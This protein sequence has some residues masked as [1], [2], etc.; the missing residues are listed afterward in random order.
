MRNTAGEHQAQKALHKT[1]ILTKAL[2]Y[3]AEEQTTFDRMTLPVSLTLAV[4]LVL[5][6]CSSKT[7][8]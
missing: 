2:P 6:F 1:Y 7:Q 5:V 4:S 8:V 3:V